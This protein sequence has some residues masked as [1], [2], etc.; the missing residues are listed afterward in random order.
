VELEQSALASRFG[1]RMLAVFAACAVLP[2][3]F[4]AALAYQ[5]TVHQLEAE[6]ALALQRE[7]KTAAMSI[8][9]RL[10]IAT[11]EL[12]I[13]R[14]QSDDLRVGAD[15]AFAKISVQPRASLRLDARQERHLEDGGP[16]LLERAHAAP[17]HLLLALAFE[18]DR[19]LVGELLP[20]FLYQPHRVDETERYWIT[21]AQGAPLFAAEPHTERELLAD[22]HHAAEHR[23]PFTLSTE[24]GPEIAV[25]WPIFLEAPF[26]APTLRVGMARPKRAI[27]RP[28]DDFRQS[29]TASVLLALLG[30][31]AI[32]LHQV[33][34][35]LRPLGELMRATRRIEAGDYSARVEIR[36][37]DE[38]ED[39]AGAFNSM[40]REIAGNITDLQT[41]ASTGARIL[42][43]PDIGAVAGELA[44]K[45]V[46]LTQARLALVFTATP[47]RD[48]RQP[49][50]ASGRGQLAPLAGASGAAG[51]VDIRAIPAFPSNAELESTSL[52]LA[53]SDCG[54]RLGVDW[55]ELE[56]LAGGALDKLVT[57][58]LQV[59]TDRTRGLLLLAGS[60]ASLGALGAERT[61]STLQILADQGAASIR[62]AELIASLRN[63]FE[64]VVQLTVEAIDEKSPYTG[65]HCRR[66]PILTELLADAA[67]AASEGPLKDFSLSEE[68][69]YELKIAALL[70]DCGKVTTPV[71]VMD[72]ATKLEAITDRIELV[73]TRAEILRRDLELDQL[74]AA[75][76]AAGAV[77]AL[78]E[79][80]LASARSALADDLAFLEA[81][82][83]GDE[84]MAASRR[85]RVDAIHARRAW[86][87]AEGVRRELVTAEEAENL[88][89]SRGTLNEVER[90][91]IEQHVTTTIRLLEQIPFPP[92]MGNVPFIAGAHHERLDGTGYPNQLDREHL[93]MQA[94]ILGL[95]DVFE[96]LTAKDRPYKPGRTLSETLRTMQDMVD[97]GHLD[98]DL[99]EVFLR[100]KIHLRYAAEHLDPH[101]IDG[102]HQAEL[103]QLTAPWSPARR[104]RSATGTGPQGASS[105]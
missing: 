35:R 53:R 22:H 77:S 57:M 20:D 52:Q 15:K 105:P 13:A 3:A 27:L 36:S 70:H 60:K 84:F 25:L 47:G 64:G 81:C 59:G 6:A 10:H 95:A 67:C 16:L 89:I 8:V 97:Q 9:E 100:S 103:E 85:E 58:P 7:A 41:L 50:D 56:A 43:D 73:R 26:Q 39:L 68:E 55:L 19:A 23:D 34:L 5:R 75:L 94:R 11:A 30:S 21:N 104:S 102:A 42:S 33:R 91:A 61:G 38:F 44:Q 82:N 45:A 37:R 24:A 98:A 99:H 87:D 31:L 49:Q 78:D 32:G 71:H 92:E 63:L 28:L 18:D 74:R 4:F 90:R 51:P 48:G 40:T 66:V 2:I 1:V 54:E 12:S 62:I 29:F 80:A 93:P 69:R 88:K 96:A 17:P 76:Q 101:Q 14:L 79:R 72:K 86:R 46:E 83:H 65:D